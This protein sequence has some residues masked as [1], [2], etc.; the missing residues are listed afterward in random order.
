VSQN[1]QTIMPSYW[2]K[3]IGLESPAKVQ[4]DSNDDIDD[5]KKA[6][7]REFSPRFDSVP[8]DEIVV[9][10]PDGVPLSPEKIIGNLNIGDRVDN[11][12]I[13]PS[14]EGNVNVL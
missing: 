11:A 1:Q 9:K 5:L 4:C 7:K 14:P 10:S 8:I 2:V 12:F 13:V 6:I 3:V